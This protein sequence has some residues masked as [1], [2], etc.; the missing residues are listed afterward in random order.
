MKLL[1][2]QG[3]TSNILQIFIRDSSS[4]TGAGLTGLL[5]SDGSLTA[6]YHQEDDTSAT[7]INLVDMTVGT[8]TSSGFKEIDSAHMPGWYQFC[9]PDASFATAKNVAFHLKGATNMAPL[10]IECQ[11]IS[12]DPYDAV[13]LGLTALPNAAAEASG[14]L[15]TRG[16]GAG[17]I[18]QPGNGM[19]DVNTIKWAGTTTTLTSGFPDVN[20]KTITAAI[21]AAGSFAANALDAVWATTAR[22]ITGGTITTVSDKTGYAL[23]TGG[24]QAIWDAL[25]SA[26]STSG[27][28]GKLLVD[29]VNA[30]ISSRSTLTAANVWDALTSG[31]STAN[32]IGKLLVD[33]VNATISSRSTLTAAN[34]WDALTSGLS[35]VGSIG[36]LLVDNVNATITSRSTLTAA[37]VW[38]QLLSAIT[39]SSSI[40]KL[41]KDNLDVVL[42]T[43]LASGS[44]TAP[45]NAGIAAIKAQ[46]DLLPGDPASQASIDARFD[47]V[48]TNL[49]TV[50]D[51]VD[52]IGAKTSGLPDDTATALSDLS[53]Q[54][55]T[56]V[57]IRRAVALPGFQFAMYDSSGDPA[58]GLTV[59]VQVSLDGGAFNTV[60]GTATAISN[61]WYTVDFLGTEMDAK[62]IAVKCHS[63][64]AKDTNFVIT[65]EGP[66]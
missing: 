5:Y 60:A 46:T 18:N 32:S 6:Y 42:S 30:T 38:D 34:V 15:Y 44:Y 51:K 39:T 27:S 3:Q 35:T 45:D 17:Q 9:P 56:L 63:S 62:V 66:A 53:T 49:E 41:I 2:K 31:L 58:T 1:A 48:D 24:V 10:P 64:G 37:N 61:G 47:T 19:V 7:Q 55:D 26:L 8:F 12:A 40:G 52:A 22:T 25:T 43:R 14:G 33:N 23:S 65:T 21:I 29:N 59:A 28:I 20:M 16:N 11:M 4:L 54:I 36:K 13:R 57:G 50:D